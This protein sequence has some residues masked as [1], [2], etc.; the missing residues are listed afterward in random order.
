MSMIG[1]FL[2]ITPEQL[3]AMHADPALV[4]KTLYPEDVD[5]YPGIDVDKAWQAIHF[6][7]VGDP[8]KGDGP[9]ALAVLNGPEIG[10]DAGYGPA[11]YL[12]PEEVRDVA[13]ALEP[14]TPEQLGQR[15]DPTA[16]MAQQIYPEIWDEDDEEELIEYI[17]EGY[18]EVRSY[19][20]DAAAKG[21]A[22]L[23]YVN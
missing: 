9:L 19:Y 17:T 2:Q 7:L 23:K 15:F 12:T 20:L 1:N 11:T 5:R 14:I 16:M 8:W 13:A 3:E 21:N 4:T 18:Q 10:D 6:L 22:M